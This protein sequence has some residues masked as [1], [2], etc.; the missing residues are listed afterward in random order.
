MNRISRRGFLERSLKLAGLTG[1]GGARLRELARLGFIENAPAGP[2]SDIGTDKGGGDRFFGAQTHFGQLRTDVDDVLGLIKGAGIGWIRDEVY[3]S[4]VEKEK[5]IFKFPPAYDH[6]L[7]AAQSRGIQVLLILDFSNSLY[8]VSEKHAPAADPERR[9][10]ARY[11]REAVEHCT[12]LGVRH[13]EIWNEP[14]ASTFWKPQPD[15]EGY[16]RLLETAYP[17]VKEADPGATVIGCSTA[18]VDLD[19]IGRVIRA[20]GS[21]FMDAVSLHPYCQPLP[22]EH[23]LLTDMAKLTRL[24]PEKPLWV[25]E[26][27]YPTHSGAAGV[28][29]EAQANYLV[30]A[31]LLARTFPSIARF[32]WYDFQND[33]E[34]SDEGEFNFGLIRMNR[35]PKPA[36]E[37][38]RRMA[39]LVGDLTP[40]EL[41]VEGD[42]YILPFG[43]GQ[44]SLFAVWRLG[45]AQSTEI[46]CARGQ[47]RIIERDG[48]S[49]DVDVSGSALTIEVSEKPRY[50]VPVKSRTRPNAGHCR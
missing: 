15:P 39:S 9:A 50:I 20:G 49:R 11:C 16:A 38:C 48:E 28:N 46:P 19:F 25:T 21:R 34:D 4:E 6:Y 8:S 2:S 22:P 44:T 43:E 29:E 42:T 14:N 10:F 1:F 13:Y 18:G 32:F 24:V 30:R 26:F 3:W 37:A 27:G 12:P 35:T 40:A 47:W 17:A 5:G 41:R 31:F 45:G 36:Y 33:G 7:R 23:R